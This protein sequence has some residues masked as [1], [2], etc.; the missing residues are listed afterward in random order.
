[1]QNLVEVRQGNQKESGSE[2]ILFNLGRDSKRAILFVLQREENGQGKVI[3]IKKF[4]LIRRHTGD[5]HNCGWVLD[6]PS[7]KVHPTA[8]LGKNVIVA[9][10]NV[11]IGECV[12]LHGNLI[13]ND[14][15]KVKK[16]SLWMLNGENFRLF[17]IVLDGM[18]TPQALERLD[19]DNQPLFLQSPSA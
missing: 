2:S 5:P 11:E 4:N 6:H 9:G 14:N 15:V 16:D 18:Y 7:V 12:G 19:S 13:I 1:M 8:F 3:E 10:F 17:D